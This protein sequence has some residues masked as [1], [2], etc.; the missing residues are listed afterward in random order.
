MNR[1]QLIDTLT[2]VQASP[3]RPILTL[4]NGDNTWL[5]SV[6]RPDNTTG[7]SF[8]HIL[9]DPWLSGPSD[10]YS[11]WFL[12]MQLKEEGALSSFK[13]VEDWIQEVETACGGTNEEDERWLD[14]VLVTH[15]NTDHLHQPTLRSLDPSINVFAVED[16]AAT[17]SAMK[18][19]KSITIVP[20]FVRGKKWPITPEMPEWLSVFRLPDESGV[21]PNLYH[22]I[23][24]GM[25]AQD[26][27]D[28]AI[29]YTPHGVEPEMV[30]AAR[31]ANPNASVLAMLHPLNECGTLGINSRGVANG[32]KIER[33]NSVRYWVNTH[34]DKLQYAG[35][36]AYFM[37][38]G[39]KTLEQGL[40]EEANEKGQEQRRPNY[41]VVGNGGSQILA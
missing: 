37:H 29:L 31:K 39:R 9:Q 16:A 25:S 6:P 28:E 12:R 15:T 20:D 10:A 40:E 36:L 13:A 1:T 27:K 14:A 34:D 7:K 2:S 32:L 22:A 35:V 18:H 41:I 17:I 5:I 11:R 21:N 38:Y 24:I 33:Q 8:Y 26:G 23:I 30:E 3:K 19:F 4:V